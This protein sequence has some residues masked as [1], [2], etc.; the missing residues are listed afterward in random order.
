MKR[1][2]MLVF[3]DGG[4]ALVCDDIEDAVLVDTGEVRWQGTTAPR[5]AG[6][7][8]AADRCACCSTRTWCWN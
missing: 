1:R 7:P 8:A 5:L 6:G 2:H 3:G 4:Q